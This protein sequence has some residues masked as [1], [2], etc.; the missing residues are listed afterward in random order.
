MIP[1]WAI[2]SR[3]LWITTTL[4][5]GKTPT[6]SAAIPFT[7]CCTLFSISMEV[8]SQ[9][10]K[11]YFSILSTWKKYFKTSPHLFHQNVH[12]Q[13]DQTGV[14]TAH[15]WRGSR[16]KLRRCKKLGLI[17]FFP[18]IFRHLKKKVHLKLLWTVKMPGLFEET[19]RRLLFPR[20]RSWCRFSETDLR[21]R[22]LLRRYSTQSWRVT[23]GT[24]WKKG[25]A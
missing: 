11:C 10:M 7:T 12:W 18:S 17:L 9:I 23:L 25:A 19:A 13:Q 14:E 16:T 3:E 21:S 22:W 5:S 2:M 8:L 6:M 4:P 24:A 1:S 15:H 20:N